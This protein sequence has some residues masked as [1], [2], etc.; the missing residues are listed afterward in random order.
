MS[1]K[2]SALLAIEPWFDRLASLADTKVSKGAQHSRR[3]GMF[4]PQI[5]RLDSSDPWKDIA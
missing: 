2:L 3:I 4:C 5:S 1:K